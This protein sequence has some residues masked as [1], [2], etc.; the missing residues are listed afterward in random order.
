MPDSLRIELAI[1]AGQL[2][3]VQRTLSGIEHGTR[4]AIRTAINKTLPR[5]RTLI[6]KEVNKKLN[7]KYGQILKTMTVKKA[8]GS[9][10]SGSILV[11]RVPVKLIEYATSLVSGV[12]SGSAPIKVKVHRAR[13]VK[14]GV[15]LVVWRQKGAE[16]LPHAFIATM[17]SGH[18]GIFRRLPNSTHRTVVKNGRKISTQLPIRELYGPTIVGVLEGEPG[19]LDELKAALRPILAQTLDSQVEWLLHKAD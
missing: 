12:S 17:P 9:Q 3:S 15:R 7:L 13:Q 18:T 19:F 14:E 11:K 16:A 4:D 8:G 5:A 6:A 10:L 1:D 2:A